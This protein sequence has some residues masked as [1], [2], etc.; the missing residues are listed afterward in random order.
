MVH[1]STFFYKPISCNQIRH[2][3]DYDQV[4]NNS[5]KIENLSITPDCSYFLL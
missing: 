3:I 5:E 4:I 1:K 2:I